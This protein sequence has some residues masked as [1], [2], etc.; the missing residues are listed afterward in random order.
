MRNLRYAALVPVLVFGVALCAERAGAAESG[1]TIY[2]LGGQAFESG[3]TPPPGF[4]V[5][6]AIGYYHGAIRT[7][8]LIGGV[9]T[10]GLDVQIA[11]PQ[12]NF[13]YVPATE[14]FGGRLGLSV[15]VP[16]GCVDL[17]AQLVLACLRDD[18]LLTA[19]T[20]AR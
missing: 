10:F 5:T 9:A 13:L 3:A 6:P 16:T 18:P 8:N 4:Y 11:L 12:V 15:N 17:D 2:P 19:D 1:F 7:N 14:I 20:D